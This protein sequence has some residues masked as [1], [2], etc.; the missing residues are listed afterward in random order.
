VQVI[1]ID[2]STMAASCKATISS[3][4]LDG[5]NFQNVT[6][7]DHWWWALMCVEVV[8]INSVVVDNTSEEMASMRKLDLPTVLKIQGLNL[9]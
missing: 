2:V 4:P 3:V 9:A 5:P 1:K 7:E 6:S 8:N